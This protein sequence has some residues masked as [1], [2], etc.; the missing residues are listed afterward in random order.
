[1]FAVVTRLWSRNML[2]KSIVETLPKCIAF[3][4]YDDTPKVLKMAFGSESPLK[5]VKVGVVN[6]LGGAAC[7][8]SS[9]NGLRVDHSR[10]SQ[11]PTLAALVVLVEGVCGIGVVSQPPHGLK[12]VVLLG[13]PAGAAY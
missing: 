13:Y 5:G 3:I 8:I 10:T 2:T 7:L 4:E 12:S 9:M 11:H 6:R 1:M